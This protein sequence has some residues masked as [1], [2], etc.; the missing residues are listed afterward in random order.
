MRF[1]LIMLSETFESPEFAP[2][3]GS[4]ALIELPVSPGDS[5]PFTL[6]VRDKSQEPW[7]A[8]AELQN[9]GKFLL[10]IDSAAGWGELRSEGAEY[11]MRVLTA[12]AGLSARRQ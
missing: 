2:Q 11:H 3:R 1:W 5:V 4:G 8:L 9:G 12:I 7:T 6:T 10:A